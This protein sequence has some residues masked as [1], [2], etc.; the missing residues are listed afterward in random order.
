MLDFETA[1][2]SFVNLVSGLDSSDQLLFHKW[3]KDYVVT[4]EEEVLDSEI[5]E[6][7]INLQV[8]ELGTRFFFTRQ[9][10][11]P[12]AAVLNFTPFR[13]FSSFQSLRKVFTTQKYNRFSF[14][15]DSQFQVSFK[16]FLSER[17]NFFY[18][19]KLLA[20]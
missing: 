20:I 16:L 5:A 4:A 8:T 6:A 17:P 9:R 1:K 2:L 19:R 11:T 10:V 18:C 7:R 12:W 13:R 14:F 15:D 3:L